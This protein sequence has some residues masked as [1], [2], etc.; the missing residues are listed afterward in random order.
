MT[1]PTQ[2]KALSNTGAAMKGVCCGLAHSCF[3]D[4]EGFVYTSGWNNQ[5]Q[6]GKSILDNFTLK[7]PKLL[8]SI[9]TEINFIASGGVHTFFITRD[10]QVFATGAN[11]CGQLGLDT[12][13]LPVEKPSKLAYLKEKISLAACGEEYSVLLSQS[14]KVFV[15]GLNNVG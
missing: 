9:G 11:H 1:L 7:E 8:N 3:L 12:E 2:I 5:G 10:G 13:G 4:S 14:R 6:C 15:S